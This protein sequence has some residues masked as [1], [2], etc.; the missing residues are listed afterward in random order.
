MYVNSCINKCMNNGMYKMYEIFVLINV[1]RSCINKMYEGVVF[2]N[3]CILVLINVW[4]NCI[5]RCI[6]KRDIK[7]SL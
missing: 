2:I 5:N 3:V 6:K 4:R 1:W 7:E